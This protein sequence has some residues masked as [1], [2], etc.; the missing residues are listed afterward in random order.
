MFISKQLVLLLSISS[1][2]SCKPLAHGV[3]SMIR[4]ADS[5]VPSDGQLSEWRTY[6]DRRRSK[7][8][9]I[10]RRMNF[11]DLF[12]VALQTVQ[13]IVPMMGSLSSGGKMQN[14]EASTAETSSQTPSATKKE[15][16]AT[17][18]AATTS[19]TDDPASTSTP[20]STSASTHHKHPS[21]TSV[22]TAATATPTSDQNTDTDSKKR[23]TGENPFN[24]KADDTSNGEKSFDQL[25]P[26]EYI[27]DDSPSEHGVSHSLFLTGKSTNMMFAPAPTPIPTDNPIE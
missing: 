9:A 3:D 26:H 5:T 4:G 14:K 27:E 18:T 22:T 2:A 8:H 23:D 6:A 24:G 12:Q 21:A 17:K 16:I 15:K 19:A 25:P 7:P 1:V 13:A 10:Q 11:E 20:S